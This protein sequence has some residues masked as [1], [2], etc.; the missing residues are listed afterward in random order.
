MNLDI[1][2]YC[3]GC[4][5]CHKVINRLRQLGEFTIE[6]REDIVM[7]KASE[8][9]GIVPVF[10][11]NNVYYNEYE[12]GSLIDKGETFILPKEE[13]TVEV[14]S[15]PISKKIHNPYKYKEA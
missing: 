3:C 1:K 2:I 11:F 8:T 7:K 10:E 14:V 15:Q 5:S 9:I 12:I 13:P 4:V 6:S